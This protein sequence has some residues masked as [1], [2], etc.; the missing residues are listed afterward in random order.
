[1]QESLEEG[2]GMEKLYNLHFNL[3][4]KSESREELGRARTRVQLCSCPQGDLNSHSVHNTLW[5]LALKLTLRA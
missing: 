3:K 5:G 4:Y 1:M 2:K